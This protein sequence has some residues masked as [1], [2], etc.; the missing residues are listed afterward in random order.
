MKEFMKRIYWGEYTTDEMKEFIEKDPVVLVPVGA[1]EQHGPHLTMNTDTVIVDSL[2]SSIVKC[3]DIPCVTLPPV[4]VG[5]S[6]HHMQFSGS[7]T[8]K[9]STMSA[10]LFDILESLHRSGISKVLVVN[11]H[12]GNMTP[13]NE[14]VTRAGSSFGGT[15]A[16]LTY[17]NLIRK[18]IGDIRKS[19]YGGISHAGEMETALQLY[20]DNGNVRTEQ[21]PVAN[22]IKGSSFW[23]A[24]MFAG[25][26]ISMYKA[27]DELSRQGHIGDPQKA[28]IE[29]GEMVHNLVVERGLQLINVI[30]E[31]ELLN[32][33]Y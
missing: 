17:W 11:S 21:I 14:A 13:L 1:Y 9:Q 29:M 16:L 33:D 25:N 23:S 4:W 24:E 15:W 8:L 28:T 31:G 12:G 2:C 19:E 20:I 5:I 26:V 22:N 6:E 7:L 18:E 3:A 10:L 30:W 27:Y 32:E